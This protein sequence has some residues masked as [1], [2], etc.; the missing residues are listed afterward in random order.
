MRRIVLGSRISFGD[1]LLLP[2]AGQ[3]YRRG[4]L[5]TSARPLEIALLALLVERAGE[6]VTKAEIMRLN[7]LMS[8]LRSRLSDTNS[9][10]RKYIATLADGYCFI[11][12][13]DRIEHSNNAAN[14]S[15]AEHAFRVGMLRLDSRQEP[16]LRE[17]VAY[18]RKAIDFNPSYVQAWVGLATAQIMMAIH[19]AESPEDAFGKARAAAEE[20]LRIDP[21]NLDA[22]TIVAWVQLCFER[23]WIA[24]R[25]AFDRTLKRKPD[26]FFAHNGMSLLQL[27]MGNS[28]ENLN[29]MVKAVRLNPLSSALRSLLA[30]SYY[31]A[32]R[33]EKAIE[34]GRR[35]LASDP[36]SCIAHVVLALSLLKLN[37]TQEA[38]QH[39]NLARQLSGE[40]RVYIGFWGYGHALA[41]LP[42]EAEKAL[43]L[44]LSLP[45]HEYIPSY[46]VGLIHLGLGR[47][48][49]AIEWLERAC[50]E[51]SHWVLFLSSDPAFDALRE[52]SRFNSL[53]DRVGLTKAGIATR[54]EAA[55]TR[56]R[57]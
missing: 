46:F 45:S 3:L 57:L 1:F 16:S 48:K 43:D 18:F 37:D 38:L 31:T 39:L 25:A 24:A 23:D 4:V 55:L 35:A 6:K 51:R 5:I 44:L 10:Q 9:K 56:R 40:S 11:H 34:M 41:G 50:D 42:S 30:H 47:A 32:R 53:L 26:S 28:Q 15:E 7:V 19:C 22:E 12:P 20:A 17:S 13:V 36:A 14:Q 29:S 49:D 52:E 21:A 54:V 2:E 27:A 33:Y 8:T